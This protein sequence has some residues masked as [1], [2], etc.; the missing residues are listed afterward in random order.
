MLEWVP[1]VGQQHPEKRGLVTARLSAPSAASSVVAVR[2]SIGAFSRLLGA[3]PVVAVFALGLSCQSSSLEL[4]GQIPEGGCPIGRGG[5]CDDAVCAALYD[6]ASGAWTQVEQCP[7]TE[8][9]TPKPEPTTVPAGFAC[10]KVAFDHSREVGGC[11]PDL[12]EPDCP[13]VA[14]E[15]CEHQVCSTGCADF[16]MC[17]PEGWVDVGHCTPEG[18]FIKLQ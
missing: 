11:E 13:A 18:A 9:N 6:C 17:E 5:T 4:C 10:E 8:A 1:P 15:L 2:V 12:L 16:F 3:I 14:A 7:L